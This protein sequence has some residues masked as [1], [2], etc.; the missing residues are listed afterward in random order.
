MDPTKPGTK[1][2]VQQRSRQIYRNFKTLAVQQILK[3]DLPRYFPAF[4]GQIDD[5]ELED[6]VRIGLLHRIENEY[7]FVHKAYGDFGFNK[8]LRNHFDE[9][10]CSRFIVDVVLVDDGYRNFRGFVDFW[11]LEKV[12]PVTGELYQRMLLDGGGQSTTQLHVAGRAGHENIFWFLYLSLASK[13]EQFKS[14]QLEI[15]D[16]LLKLSEDGHTAFLDYFQNCDDNYD[17]LSNILMNFGSEFLKK[18]FT[19]K[20]RNDEKLLY[21]IYIKYSRNYSKVSSFLHETF[22]DDFEFLREVSFLTDHDQLGPSS[23][24]PFLLDIIKVEPETIQE[25]IYTLQPIIPSSKPKHNLKPIK[26]S[27]PKKAPPKQFECKKCTKK[28]LFD[29]LLQVHYK[30]FHKS[31][32]SCKRCNKEFE[33]ASELFTHQAI[34]QLG[35]SYDCDRCGK[36]IK[37]K[38]HLIDHLYSHLKNKTQVCPLC[39]KAFNR[40]DVLRRHMEIHCNFRRTRRYRCKI[41]G[42]GY[43]TE[44]DLKQ[45]S[46]THLVRRNTAIRVNQTLKGGTV[47]EN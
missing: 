16:Y 27:L 46:I 22:R 41:C 3:S 39:N 15:Q 28:F 1:R 18:V 9:E 29:S 44:G 24:E 43:R 37:S 30:T 14:R 4:R 34:H 5:D 42:M 13:T 32:H 7:K 17:L 11:I 33:T 47:R 31:I 36:Q 26:K 25:P 21:A 6:L 8:F 45:H 12:G 40:N 19:V 38:Y 10:F 20:M 35:K 23:Q 2:I